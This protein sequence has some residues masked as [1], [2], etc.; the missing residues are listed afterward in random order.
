MTAHELLL[1][2]AGRIPDQTLA[3][4]RRMLADGAVTSAIALVASQV[5]QA[6]VP[7]TADELAAIRNLAGYP[8]ALPG[9]QPA[10]ALPALRFG[11][12]ELDEEGEVQHDDLD[13]ALAAAAETHSAGLAA[14][15]RSWRYRLPD[16]MYLTRP[17]PADPAAADPA[18]ADAAD[19]PSATPAVY[20]PDDPD[21]EY[22]V[23]IVQVDDPGMIRELS[24]H[25]LGV[26]PDP[27][28]AGVEII[29]L[30]DEPFPYQGAALDESLLLWAADMELEP[31]FEVARVFDFAD[32][33]TGP[34]FAPDHPVIDDPGERD[35]L[36]TYLR[37]GYPVLTTT[38]AM[39]DILD[40]Q[41]GDVVPTSFRTD[42][43]WIWTD[44]VQYYLDRHGLA[45]DARLTEHIGAQLDWGQFLPD[46]D[47]QTAIRAA[48]FLMNPP[49]P[50]AEAAAWF[51]GDD[52][53][54][55]M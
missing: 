6:P 40:P 47:Q 29:T 9:V 44:T 31:E 43:E 52:A 54:D 33:V 24:A 19:E 53:A 8:D 14:V 30:E 50:E 3:Q 45:P 13:E 22:R 12:S 7:L 37:G 10:G 35:R 34:G 25:L 17:A 42:G 32:P 15:W 11:F 48:E 28:A 27:A 18:A 46:A 23:Y 21:R 4:A 5:T 49:S 51:P 55:R 26:I 36:L 1:R 2:L 20:D 41:A 16:S 39:T 38:A